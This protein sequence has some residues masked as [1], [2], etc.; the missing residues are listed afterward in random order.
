ME[1][2]ME[3]RISSRNKTNKGLIT[4]EREKE[5]PISIRTQTL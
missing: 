3:K 5:K 2:R 4:K 1:A